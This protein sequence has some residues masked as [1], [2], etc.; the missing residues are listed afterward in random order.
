[1]HQPA[2]INPYLRNQVLT[3]SPEQLRL[4]LYD[5][6]LRFMRAGKVGLAEKN[7]DISG[8]LLVKSEGRWSIAA[9]AWDHADNEKHV[10][11]QLRE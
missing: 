4:M 6:A 8:Y 3:A 2:T 11:D 7:Y 10:P 1:M 9:H 5:G